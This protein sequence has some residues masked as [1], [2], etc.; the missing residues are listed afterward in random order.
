MSKITVHMIGQAHLDPVWLWRWTEGRAEALG[1]SQSAVDR[2]AEYPDFHFTRGE[3][4][5]YSWIETENPTLFAQIRQAINEGRWHV[6]NGMIIQPDM[7][8]PNGESFVRQVLLGKH[9]MRSQLGVEP[10]VAYCVDSFGHAGTLPQIL[11]ECGFDSYVFMRPG[12]HE[13]TLPANVFWWQGP[14]GS[15]ILTFRITNAYTTRSADQEAHI[16]AAVAAKPAQIDATMCFF[17]IGNHG[18]GPTKEQIENVRTLAVKHQTAQPALDIRF[19][20][21][22][23]YFDAIRPQA[24]SLPTVTGELQ[25]HAVGC[26]SVN[27]ALKHA[28]RQAENRLLLAERLAVMANLWADT[29][30]PQARLNE[31]WHTLAFNQFHDTLGGTSIKVAADDAIAELN[32]VAAAADALADSVARAVANRID[33]A[34]QGATVVVFNPASQPVST[35]LEYE[36]WTDWQ[37]WDEHGWGLVDDSGQPVAYQNID[38]LEAFSEANG[39]IRRLLFAT[40]LPAFGYRLFRFAPG[41][42]Q[43][44]RPA[45]S[46][47]VTE[48]ALENELLAIRLDS[49]SG[50]II[51]CVD[52]R[53]GQELV[54]PGG[55]NVGEVLE[56]YSDT[57][58]H[59]VQRYGA[60]VGSFGDAKIKIGERGPLRVSLLIERNYGASIWQQQLLLCSGESTLT[61]RNWLVWLEPWRLLK[62]TCDVNTIA[63]RAVH[64][65]PF[66]WLERPCDG[67]EVPTHMW[68]DVSGPTAT[69]EMVGLALLNNG[70]YGCDVSGSTLRL[71]ILRCVPY[72]YHEPHSFGVRHHYD[73]VDRG[74]Q[75]F[76][77][78]LHPYMG[79]WPSTE[80]VQRARMLNMPPLLVTM[81]AHPGDLPPQASLAKVNSNDIEMT[82][83]KL[84][85]DGNGYIVRLADVHGCGG[86]GSLVWLDQPFLLEWDPFEVL[87][88]RLTQQE[89]RWQMQQCDMLEHIK[90]H[91]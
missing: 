25:Y 81:H 19:S 10:T 65:V 57:W 27:S 49:H 83:C 34:G 91:A 52:K 24:E 61:I 68:L 64:D 17:G 62:L 20:W 41:L 46:L 38:P 73:W 51:S 47:Y 82:A 33:T 89:G 1:T 74:S 9:Y 28:H 35:Y 7:N 37:D 85:E 54:G 66:G 31:L 12:P 22:D 23:A 75:E 30:V 86:S 2:L 53:S 16:L 72:A 13:K 90:R 29:P 36:P 79:D 43:A 63:P 15:R 6:V 11:R 84:A 39:K 50:N 77:I 71:T 14:N 70:K 60:V 56:D 76:T 26:Y 5:V 80:I 42:P 87:T 3:S 18:G 44:D 4:Q 58:S 55:W 21:P 48:T 69:G 32:G 88:V 78:V 40:T 45:T 8:L 67:H 59:G